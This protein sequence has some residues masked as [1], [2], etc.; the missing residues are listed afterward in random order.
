MNI[1]KLLA[2]V[3]L[4]VI[5]AVCL[6]EA[7]PQALIAPQLSF[8]FLD[9][10]GHP[11]VAGRLYSCVS[12]GS[13]PGSPQAVYTSSS[14]FTSWSNPIVLDSAGRA[15]GGIWLTAGSAYKFVLSSS[16]GAVIST[17]DNIIGSPTTSG[18]GGSGTPGGSTTNVQFNLLGA[19]AGSGNFTWNNTTRTLT[20]NGIA[21][22]PG[23]VSAGGF[24]QSSGGFLSSVTGGSWQGFNTNTDGSLFRAYALAQNT[25][26][27]AGGY[28]ALAPITY[29]PYNGAPCTDVYGNPVQQPVPLNGLSSFGT[30]DAIVWV[31]TSPVM[32]SGGS[33]GAPLPVNTTYGINTNTYL[34]ARGGF[35]TDNAAYNSIQSLQGGAYVKLGVTVDQALYPKSTADCTTLNTPG[36]GYGGFAYKTNNNYCYYNSTTN[37]WATV[38]L[39]ASGGGATPG[40]ATTNVQ[41]NAAGAFGGSANMTWNNATRLFTVTALNAT[42]AGIAVGTG[43]MQADK[44]FL[45]TP[46]VANLYNSFYAP[47]GGMAALSFTATKYVNTG[48]NNGIPTATSGD[49]FNA[50]AIYCDTPS[51]GVTPCTPKLYDGTAWVSLAT[52]GATSPGGATTNVQFNSGGA[53]AGSANLTYASQLLTSVASSS[54]T[55]GIAVQTGYAQADAGF[56]G[57]VGTCVNWNC[58]QAPGGGMGAKSFTAAS[59]VQVGTYSSGGV[60]TPP[61]LTSGDTFHPGAI[62]WDTDSGGNLKV[63]NGISWNLVSSGGTPGGPVTA[64]QYNGGSGFAGTANFTWNNTSRLLTI[65]TA[66]ATAGLSLINGFAQ[67]DG[68]FLT[69][70]IAG[71]AIQAPAGGV[72]ANSLLA[73]SASDAVITA[74]TSAGNVARLRL[75]NNNS[76]RNWAISSW[77]GVL[78][79]GTFAISDDTAAAVRMTI[80]TSGTVAVGSRLTA[81]TLYVNRTTDDTSGGVLQVLG[82]ASATSGYYTISSATNAI[83]A[84]NGGVT[85]NGLVATSPNYN[86]IQTASGMAARSFT[87][88]TYIQAGQ[89]NGAPTATTADTINNGAIYYDT[90]LS[91]LRARIAGTFVSLSTSAALSSINSQTGP[92]ITLAGTSNQVLVSSGANT[93]TLSTPQSIGTS[94]AVNFS[95]VTTSSFVASSATGASLAFQAGGGTFQV[96]GAGA[97]ST[98]GVLTSTAGVNVTTTVAGNSI[99]TSGGINVTGTGTFGAAISANGGITQQLGTNAQLQIGTGNFY[100][101]YTGASSAG[102]GC[103]GISD[104]WQALTSDN[105]LVVCV[106]GT[107]YR[108]ALTTY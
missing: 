72:T 29:N 80:D 2:R 23:L 1:S 98:G 25:S 62:S 64:V 70:S 28:L 66:G 24:I 81:A 35:A 37:T 73:S 71:N 7:R 13:C 36:A 102:I 44:G 38:D 3:V 67:A 40:G 17:I 58:F 105:F 57:T 51:A 4:A 20:L 48:F 31:G 79:N 26:N 76:G 65:T 34:F 18:G 101:R 89:S 16:S 47:S 10:A 91:Q 33:C 39:S 74:Q 78:P 45:A 53:F 93:I 75:I 56:L 83:Q 68:G 107:R 77:G 97:I 59:Y 94:S 87:A 86:A 90:G 92:A 108:A 54:L 19:F 82:S 84:P 21:G 46:V 69:A 60:G 30:N 6:Q 55:A 32:P 85:A 103:V 8:Q 15:P 96:S 50:G 100:G 14:A 12:G 61:P 52:G 9:N 49:S 106:G 5:G 27:N 99:Q 88:T 95:T 41:Y 22:T 63:Y 104:G 43:Y 42:S 11:L